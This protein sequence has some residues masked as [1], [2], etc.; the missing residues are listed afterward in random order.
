MH[1]QILKIRSIPRLPESNTSFYLGSLSH[2]SISLS[3][4]TLVPLTLALV[5]RRAG[6]SMT[7]HDNSTCST[8]PQ[9]VRSESTVL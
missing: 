2:R 4:E 1:D 8:L 5:L 3:T 7:A 6:D 9:G